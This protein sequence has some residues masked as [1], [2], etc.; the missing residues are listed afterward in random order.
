VV[1]AVAAAVALSRKVPVWAVLVAASA[2]GVVA[3]PFT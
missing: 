1:V 2:V 3:A